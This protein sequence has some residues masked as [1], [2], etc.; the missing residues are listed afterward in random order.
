MHPPDLPC[1]KL[2]EIQFASCREE[3]LSQPWLDVFKWV[4]TLGCISGLVPPQ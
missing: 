4:E 2:P 3:E 1:S